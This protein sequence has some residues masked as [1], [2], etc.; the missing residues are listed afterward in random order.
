ML[1]VP[2]CVEMVVLGARR[3][4]RGAQRGL[5]DPLFVLYFQPRLMAAGSLPSQKYNLELP[6][7]DVVKPATPDS[8]PSWD[9]FSRGRPIRPPFAGRVNTQSRTGNDQ[10]K[11]MKLLRSSGVVRAGV[12][13]R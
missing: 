7:C 2:D 3:E 9:L 4:T 12:V 5:E 13:R 8:A 11:R 10:G 1:M 6:H